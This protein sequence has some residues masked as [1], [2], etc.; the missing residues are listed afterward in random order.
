ML[1]VLGLGDNVCDIYL[2]TG[3]MYPGGQALNVAVFSKMLGQNAEYMGVFG[4]DSVAAC[5]KQTLQ[6]LGIPFTHSRTVT[7]ENGYA[8]VRLN[9]GDRVFVTSNKGGVLKDNPLE[10]SDDDFSY[11]RKFDIVHT[12]NNSYMDQQLCKLHERG[13]CISYDFSSSWNDEERL[14]KVCGAVDVVFLS[15]P[16]LDEQEAMNLAQRIFKY[17]EK[18]I[19][20][21]MGSNGAWCYSSERLYYQPITPVNA[22]DTLGAGDSFTAQFLVEVGNM[23]KNE[24]LR[25][26]RLPSYIVCHAL[27]KASEFAAKTCMMHGAF[28]YG[29]PIAVELL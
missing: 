10:F 11:V 26:N 20:M 4:T 12:S 17:G 21:T 23:A 27:Q 24:N 2:N 25:M 5:V 1:N 29:R 14:R 19:V 8:K 16:K 7:G 9:N 22:V 18:S 6:N 15:T 13:I 28:G 3:Y